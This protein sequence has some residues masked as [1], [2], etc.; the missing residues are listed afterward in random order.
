MFFGVVAGV[1]LA[2]ED[3]FLVGTKDVQMTLMFMD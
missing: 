2:E 3:P 1:A